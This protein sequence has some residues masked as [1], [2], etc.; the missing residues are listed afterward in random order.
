M[1]HDTKTSSAHPPRSSAGAGVRARTAALLG[2]VAVLLAGLAVYALTND[3]PDAEG[4]DLQTPTSSSTASSTPDNSPTDSSPTDTASA[5]ATQTVT[6]EEQAVLDAYLAF[7]A[8]L[9]QAQADPVRS[10][11]Y[12][13]PV[14][15]G[16][17]FEVTNGGIKAELL[18][19]K[20]S[21][22]SPVLRP[23]V[24][25]IDGSNAVVHDCQDTSGVG[26]RMVGATEAL[27]IGR[28]PSSAETTLQMVEG[29]WK[30]AATDFKE[31]PEVYCS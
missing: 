2:V 29:T 15:T 27:T 23:V 1:T 14:A 24:A 13:A 18:D 17:Q 30:V 26:S 19:G 8:A 7:Y 28:N 20:E 31:P 10:Q 6:A 3:G 16:D 11:D 21:F 12:L 9:D 5:P 4:L 25:S 22:G